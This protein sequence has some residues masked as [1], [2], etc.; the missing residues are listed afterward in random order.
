MDL[1]Q[2][3]VWYFTFGNDTHKNSNKGFVFSSY[4]GH[5]DSLDASEN[6]E[7]ATRFLHL[8]EQ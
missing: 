3:S 5:G 7:M 8:P 4:F 6:L 2:V 1:S